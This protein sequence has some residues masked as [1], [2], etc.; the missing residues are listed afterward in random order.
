LRA[1]RANSGS[2]Y[3]FFPAKHDLLLAVLERYRSEIEPRLLAPAWRGVADPIERVFA[4]LR[5]YRRLLV[6]T[7]FFYGCPVGSLALEIHEPDPAVRRLLAANF[8]RWTGA[9]RGC[10]AAARH[11]LAADADPRELSLFVLSVMEGAVM[12]A[13]THRSLEAFDASVG[14]LRDYFRRLERGSGSPV[15][16]PA[17][18]AKERPR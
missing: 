10:L 17:P 12:Q 14:R 4:L 15:R 3:H 5:V 6:A 11:R 1:A 13:R 7:D 8:E 18:S 2:L 9:V 16:R